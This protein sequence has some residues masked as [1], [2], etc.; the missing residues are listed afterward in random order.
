MRHHQAGRTTAAIAV[1]FA[2]AISM[3]LIHVH[4]LAMAGEAAGGLCD[5]SDRL[6]C[7][8]AAASRWSRIGRIPIA[9]L[10]LGWYI[11][12]SMLLA[13]GSR[14]ERP[15]GKGARL[16]LLAGSLGGVGYSVVLAVVSVV[17]IGSLCPGC[18]G[19]YLCNGVLL[20]AAWR[21]CGGRAGIAALR[22][23]ARVAPAMGVV[24]VA[25][26]ATAASG[27][28]LAPAGL[29]PAPVAQLDEVGGARVGHAPSMGP[30]D[31]AV[32]IVEFSDFQCP[33]CS[34]LSATM[35]RIV[36]TFEG[37]VRVE[38]R[39]CPLDFHEH[40]APAARAAVCAD[41]QGRFWELHDAMFGAQSRLDPEGLRALATDAGLD[42]EALDACLESDRPGAV[43]D[44]DKA[45]A[46]ELGVQGTPSFFV[47]GELY[48]GALPYEDVEAIVRRALAE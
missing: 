28:A 6:N 17:E 29:P 1:L 8:G 12:A 47:N 48:V 21:W 27:M 3:Y 18:I 41:E 34:R 14:S 4:H 2:A 23:G 5:V 39:H 7:A 43:V 30:E 24:M 15:A 16:L 44:A 32:V 20:W 9:L 22:D 31:A 36:E 33:Y 11:G 26:V 10:G 42:L 37:Q 40:A 35:H 19:L 13:V 45:A 25:L 46:G 38:F